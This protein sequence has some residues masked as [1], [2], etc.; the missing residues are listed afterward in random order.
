MQAA[1]PSYFQSKRMFKRNNKVYFS[2]PTG[3][4][5]GTFA[6]LQLRPFFSSMRIAHSNYLVASSIAPQ[7]H[8][9]QIIACVID[10]SVK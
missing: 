3:Y 6:L 2:L 1:V 8:F 7:K 10:A 9:N 4:W 5:T